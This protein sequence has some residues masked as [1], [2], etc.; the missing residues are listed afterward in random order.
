[1]SARIVEVRTSPTRAALHTPF[2]TAVRR[3]DAVES[4]YV[5]VVD[6]DGAVGRGEG[7]ATWRVTGD[8]LASITAA[9]EGPLRAAVLDRDPDDLLPACRAVADAVVGNMAAKAAVDVALHDLAARRTGVPLT[10]LLGTTRRSVPTDVT[11]AA[12]TVD[13]M[14]AAAAKRIDE[15][16]SVLKVKVGDGGADDLARLRA[17]RG[18]AP[19]A[20]LRLDAN[21]GWAPRQAVRIIRSFSD[22]GLDIEL[23][24]QPTAAD[25]LDGLAFVTAR[26]DTPILADESVWSAADTL[27]LVRRRAADLVN[28]K[29]AKSGGLAPARAVAT[30]AEAAGVGVLVGSMMET[31][32]GTAA[33]AAFAC[34]L[35]TPYVCDLDAAW[36]LATLPEDAGIGYA[37]GIVHLTP[38]HRGGRV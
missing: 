1:M 26:V 21:Q 31:C 12:D 11:L 14:A 38:D 9:A 18:A 6:S 4:V 34:A 24:E 33:A 29:L 10:K 2:V 25:D 19:D 23:V 8:S 32:V 17:I 36:W 5:D 15:G 13:A 27:E 20:L 16:F 22:A 37:D 28:V 7:V 3:T 30:V 35:G